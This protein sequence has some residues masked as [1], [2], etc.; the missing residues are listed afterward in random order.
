MLNASPEVF[1]HRTRWKARA[2]YS[3]WPCFAPK[4][5]FF[6]LAEQ[7]RRRFAEPQRL[8]QPQHGIPT[9]AERREKEVARRSSQS[10]GG[11]NAYQAG[12]GWQ[13]LPPGISVERYTSVAV[14]KDLP[15]RNTGRDTP[16][17]DPPSL[18]ELRR[19]GHFPRREH[20]CRPGLHRPGCGGSTPPSRRARVANFDSEVPALNR[21]EHGAS[22]WRP[23][24][25]SEEL[26]VQNAE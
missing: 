13:A 26:R 17:P 9:S 14:R 18:C 6:P 2:G 7:I 22:P 11:L 5:A 3:Q 25:S 12:Y 21:R 10:E 15:N 19:A 20:R 4:I 8:V 1:S 24:I 16:M 23:T